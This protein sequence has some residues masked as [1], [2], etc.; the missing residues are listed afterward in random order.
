MV[1]EQL[2]LETAV[3]KMTGLSIPFNGL[4]KQYHS[5]RQ[6]ILDI[7]DQVLR[8]GQVMNGN[9]TVEFEHWLC[10]KNSVSHAVTCHSG[11]Q[12]LEIIAQ[13]YHEN[14][15]LPHPRVAIPAVTYPATANAFVRSGW[16]VHFIDVDCY[17]IIDFAKMPDQ[18][19]A[20]MVMVGLYGASI[21]HR[22]DT[23]WWIRSMLT[24]LITIED[25]AQ[26][27]LSADCVRTGS[28]AAISFDPTK[29]LGNFGNGGA[30]LTNDRDLAEYARNWRDN[31]KFSGFQQT[32]TNSRMSELDCAQLL[33]KT[34]YLDQW[35]Q[36]RRDIVNYWREKL[37]R[38]PVR[39]LIDQSNT[40]DHCFHKFVIDCDNRDQ[41][42]RSLSARLIETRIHY[43]YPLHE[44]GNYRQYPAPDLLNRAS[45]L[46]RRVISLPIYPELTDLEVEY[47]A[48]QVADSVLKHS[49]GH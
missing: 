34:N 26:H 15:T 36:R 40:Q 13:Y 8:S 42:Q 10:K 5:I 1:E 11:T 14:Q 23:Q 6:P 27:W 4:K 16:E 37:G 17:G 49:V 2:V 18:D 43:E 12:A 9:W 19:F 25:A 39:C 44:L 3:G 41:V 30:V 45:A 22:G 28:A 24:N 47:I 7:T 35:Q 38:V 46:C 33:I 21:R 20:A 31:G 29:N 48:D 32:G